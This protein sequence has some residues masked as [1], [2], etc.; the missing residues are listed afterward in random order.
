MHEVI[1]Y[2][3]YLHGLFNG[4]VILLFLYQGWLGL[5][6]RRDR[7][8]GRSKNVSIIKRHRKLGPIFA[9]MGITGFFA[10]ALIV[11][12]HE[13]RIFVHPVHFIIGLSIAALISIT[14]FISR[15]IKGG[16][17][18]F[19]TPHL[20]IGGVIICLYFIQAFIGLSK[21]LSASH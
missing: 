12:L 21:L 20:F 11:Y 5:A 17:S 7:T 15:K 9:L 14:Y 16:T 1:P 8:A 18:T 10:G 13:G 2:L 6:I 19:R 4:F 3:K